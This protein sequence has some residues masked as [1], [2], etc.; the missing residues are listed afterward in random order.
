M[1]PIHV[2]G[3]HMVV[4][5]WS[6]N[7]TGQ[8]LYKKTGNSAIAKQLHKVWLRLQAWDAVQF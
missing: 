4:Q 6:V 2:R 1:S 8:V 7:V 5:F 3:E